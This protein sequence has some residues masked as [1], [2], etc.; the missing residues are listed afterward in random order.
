MKKRQIVIGLFL[1]SLGI[2]GGVYATSGMP[3]ELEVAE[4]ELAVLDQNRENT[5]KQTELA[6]KAEEIA[7]GMYWDKFCRIA[8]LK[9]AAGQEFSNPDSQKNFEKRCLDFPTEQ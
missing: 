5:K 3:S 7:E 4:K 6:V 8:F 2:I 1:V 9:K